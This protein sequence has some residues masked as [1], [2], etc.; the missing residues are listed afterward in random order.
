ML[1][2]IQVSHCNAF[3]DLFSHAFRSVFSLS[4]DYFNFRKMRTRMESRPFFVQLLLNWENF[5]VHLLCVSFFL[6]LRNLSLML[7]L[8]QS[9]HW[10]S[11]FHCRNIWNANEVTGLFSIKIGGGVI[12]Q[13]GMVLEIPIFLLWVHNNLSFTLFFFSLSKHKNKLPAKAV[14]S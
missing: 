1:S 13:N 12:I 4:S 11:P 2:G 3:E 9:I 6:S 8:W 14:G 7:F 5:I 10:S